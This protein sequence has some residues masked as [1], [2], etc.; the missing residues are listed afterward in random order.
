MLLSADDI[1]SFCRS[2]LYE[3]LVFREVNETFLKELKSNLLRCFQD[4]ETYGFLKNED[5][6]K[7]LFPKWVILEKYIKSKYNIRRKDGWDQ[8]FRCKV[9]KNMEETN[10]FDDNR[11]IG[12]WKI[13]NM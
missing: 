2:L 4:E 1:N 7:R 9:Y 10:V 6:W 8:A 12:Q 13:Y 3:H 5:R 11:E